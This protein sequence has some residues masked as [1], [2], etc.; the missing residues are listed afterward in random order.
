MILLGLSLLSMAAALVVIYLAF[1]KL[2]QSNLHE[3]TRRHVAALALVAGGL[4]VFALFCVGGLLLRLVAQA[5]L[6]RRTSGAT[7]YVNA[8]EIAGHRRA[9][10]DEEE[11]GELVVADESGWPDDQDEGGP[12]VEEDDE[13]DD[14]DWLR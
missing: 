11:L 2:L 13:P 14:D 4:I 7:P 9:V 12:A 5:L 10:P 1:A 3:D 6:R 8:W